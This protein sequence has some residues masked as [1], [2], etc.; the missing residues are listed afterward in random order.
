VHTHPV[1]ERE[2]CGRLPL[3]KYEGKGE[4]R[5]VHAYAS[6]RERCIHERDVSHKLPWNNAYDEC[7]MHA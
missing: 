6:G 5:F 3:N 7:G 1:A 2:T 4:G